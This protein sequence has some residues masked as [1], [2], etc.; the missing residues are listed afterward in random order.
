[1]IDQLASIRDIGQKEGVRYIL[2][3]SIRSSLGSE[4]AD[5][6]TEIA[7]AT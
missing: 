6:A 5:V 4:P 3:K 1:M 7:E 2:N